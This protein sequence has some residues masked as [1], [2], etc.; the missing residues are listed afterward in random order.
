MI[1]VKI[2]LHEL[3]ASTACG[4]GVEAFQETFGEVYETDWTH[5]AQIALITGPCKYFVGWA[6]TKNLLPQINLRDANLTYADL[7]SADLRGAYLEGA[8]LTG[9]YLTGADLRGADLRDADLRGADL[10][11]ANLTGADLR[12]ADLTGADLRRAYL[13]GAIGYTP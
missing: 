5:A 6:V 13:T 7:R 10:R 12:G 4:D 9:A 8:D 2:T 11:G 3:S 1:H